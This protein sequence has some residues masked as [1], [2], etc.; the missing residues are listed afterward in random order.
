[1]HT[2]GKTGP[3]VRVWPG[4]YTGKM[5]CA[6]TIFGSLEAAAYLSV[7]G[8]R[9]WL[10]TH[11]LKGC[12]CCRCLW[13]LSREASLA[14]THCTFTRW[15]TALSVNSL[16]TQSWAQRS[17]ALSSILPTGQRFRGML[18]LASKGHSSM[19]KRGWRLTTLF[20]WVAAVY[21]AFCVCV[22]GAFLYVRG[23]GG[24]RQ[25]L[26][27]LS[28]PSMPSTPSLLLPPPRRCC[29]CCWLCFR[30]CAGECP[31]V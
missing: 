8:L 23:G 22:E 27:T 25:I 16:A 21:V 18:C 6:L 13:R 19:S 9:P 15:A 14:A 24:Q 31:R 10:P 29:C 4:V 1:V 30:I 5:A 2:S 3:G 26:P 11:K 17:A 20:R 7:Q 12:C 28:T